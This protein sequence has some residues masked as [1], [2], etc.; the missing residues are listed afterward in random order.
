MIGRI[1]A[2]LVLLLVGAQRVFAVGNPNA[3]E[4][5][6]NTSGNAVGGCEG[7]RFDITFSPIPVGSLPAGNYQIRMQYDAGAGWQNWS[8][9]AQQI[10][11]ASN[12]NV[13]YD[14]TTYTITWSAGNGIGPLSH[15]YG[16]A[17]QVRFLLTNSSGVPVASVSPI[18]VPGTFTATKVIGGSPYAA[19]VVHPLP[20]PFT[21]TFYPLEPDCSYGFRASALS[22]CLDG[23]TLVLEV[24][25]QQV[26]SSA[27]LVGSRA[28]PARE[29]VIHTMHGGRDLMNGKTYAWKWKSRPTTL[30]PAGRTITVASGTLG[31]VTTGEWQ[32]EYA[33][34]AHAQYPNIDC[35]GGE[36]DNND[37]GDTD[38]DGLPDN[39]DPDI[40]GDGIPN[41]KDLD[42]NG[43][44]VADGPDAPPPSNPTP[45]PDT[46]GTGTAPKPGQLPGG[47][48]SGANDDTQD[49][50]AEVLNA[51][52]DAGKATNQPGVSE[53][54]DLGKQPEHVGD[55]SKVKNIG[56]KTEEID[57]AA[58][59]MVSSWASRFS[60][61]NKVDLPSGFGKRTQFAAS[62][63][64]LGSVS[65]SLSAYLD[66]INAFRGLCL[67]VV[68]I[69]FWF[70]TIKVIRASIA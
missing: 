49:I 2:C 34:M 59:G 63:P 42:K 58:R 37:P 70:A 1:L 12:G 40:D 69:V 7:T 50:Y 47:G 45:N 55:E 32:S 61:N 20:F 38:G 24:D 30:Y 8:T 18:V 36:P 43:D 5:Y 19:G 56:N 60:D 62:L 65:I 48:P 54:V 53:N 35:A 6:Y 66:Y 39:E 21:V 25:G 11:V 10:N 27:L 68:Y 44:G 9:T 64:L 4:S 46:G 17:H 16:V 41:D 31:S 29:T 26:A 57:G 67:L 23:A 22:T 33:W 13:T 52:K 15:K 3:P 14:K 51:L 28:E